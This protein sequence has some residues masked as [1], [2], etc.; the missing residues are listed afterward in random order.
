[1]AKQSLTP[2][3]EEQ[4]K[5]PAKASGAATIA[6][7]IATNFAKKG[8]IKSSAAFIAAHSGAIAFWGI[9]AAIIVGAVLYALTVF[10]TVSPILMPA[11]V[12][13]SCSSATSNAKIRAEIEK[14]PDEAARAK[15]LEQYQKSVSQKTPSAGSLACMST[16]DGE[17]APP[18]P[19]SINP[20]GTFTSGGIHISSPYGP[21]GIIC[22]NY[23]CTADIHN[24]ID[25]PAAEGT[26]VSAI[27]SGTVIQ[28]G[29]D[30]NGCGNAVYI[31][32]D[33]NITTWYCHNSKVLVSKGESVTAG[34][35]ISEVGTT[36]MSTGNHL[37]LSIRIN[38]KFVDPYPFFL[39]KGVDLY[40][41][42]G[43]P[44]GH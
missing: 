40:E 25:F 35:P 8:I 44:R 28:A 31:K 2:E 15:A 27:M 18:F 24:G 33:A 13:S 36:G 6:G 9:L 5:Q 4:V 38:N 21:R 19:S 42:Y 14:I 34:Q 26:P 23:G 20:D 43:Q 32:T 41:I 39:E 16:F 30:N 22:T 37:H 12:G 17:L 3:P 11:S 1:M 29:W 10:A 7:N